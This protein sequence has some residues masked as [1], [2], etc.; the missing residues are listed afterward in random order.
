MFEE[1]FQSEGEILSG[2]AGWVVG[3][4]ACGGAIPPEGRA[5]VSEKLVLLYAL[6]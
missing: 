3:G 5:S 6:A 1:G 4:L 2:G